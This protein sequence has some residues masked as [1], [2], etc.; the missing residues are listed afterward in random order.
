MLATICLESVGATQAQDIKSV[1]FERVV[2]VAGDVDHLDVVEP[3]NNVRVTSSWISYQRKV[4][5]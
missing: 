4:E 1:E 3:A 2:A 5:S